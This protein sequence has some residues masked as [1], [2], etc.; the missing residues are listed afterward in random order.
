MLFLEPILVL[1]TIYLSII[2]GL[3]YALFEAIPVIFMERRG[4]DEGQNGLIFIGIGIGT[5]IGALLNLYF[6]RDY[7]ELSKKWK[8]FP[9]PEERLT[10]AKVG[11]PM[12]VIAIFWLGWTGQYACV[13]WYV[14]AVSTI[15]IG[16]GISMIFMS[17]L[18]GNAFIIILTTLTVGTGLLGGY[19]LDVLCFCHRGEHDGTICSRSG[20]PVVY[21]P[22]VGQSKY[23][24]LCLFL[25]INFSSAWYKLDMYSF[26]PYCPS[27]RPLSVPIL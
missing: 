20:L 23:L 17:F 9:P 22:D 21:C 3:L 19:I 1:I 11:A 2:Y 10:C 26:R 12:F 16:A 13:P 14:P 18:V 6:S 7:K 4:F 5:T 8:G 24:Y 15:P 27:V 25:N